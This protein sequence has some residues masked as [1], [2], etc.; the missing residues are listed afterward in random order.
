M[1]FGRAFAPNWAPTVST[2]TALTGTGNAPA[3]I[4]PDTFS[5]SSID[6]FPEIIASP[7][8]IMSFTTGSV[9]VSLSIFIAIFWPLYFFVASA[10][11]CLPS[12]LS[13]N[14]ITGLPVW[15]S[16]YTLDFSTSFPVKIT[17]FSGPTNV[18][19]PVCWRESTIVFESYCPGI[20]ILILLFPS[21]VTTVSE[22]PTLLTLKDKSSFVVFNWSTV[23]SSLWIS[24]RTETPPCKSNP[25]VITSLNVLNW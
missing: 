21:V 15:G 23:T 18:N 22:T 12:S 3:F 5:A 11:F 20:S 9:N 17:S 6:L 25:L 8:E 7:L 2:E 14:F 13:S 1:A 19:S 4:I 16:I 10:N 24:I